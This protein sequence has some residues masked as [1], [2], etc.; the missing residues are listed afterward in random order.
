VPICSL[1]QV[2]VEDS[3]A[4]LM[5]MCHRIC[6]VCVCPPSLSCSRVIFCFCL[7]DV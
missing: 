5:Y 6:D 2:V 3:A 1:Q 4:L 7:W